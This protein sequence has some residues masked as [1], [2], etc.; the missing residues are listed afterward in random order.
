MS[1]DQLLSALYQSEKWMNI[2]LEDV[3]QM[4]L[5][6]KKKHHELRNNKIRALYG[7]STPIKIHIKEVVPPKLSNH[8]TSREF[9]NLISEKGLLPMSRQYVH[10]SEDIET[11]CIVGNRK[12]LEPV[13][14]IIDTDESRKMELS[15]I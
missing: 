5:L 2:T 1:V 7:Q 3:Q 4:I 15:F 8:G 13:I 14:L 12:T 9:M 11:A 6:S 10:L